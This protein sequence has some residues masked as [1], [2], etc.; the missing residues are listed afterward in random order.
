MTPVNLPVSCMCVNERE[1]ERDR[2]VVV[3]GLLWYHVGKNKVTGKGSKRRPA[4]TRSAAPA[5]L[6][7]CT[8]KMHTNIR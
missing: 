7:T 5:G 4:G 8:E 3:R 2:G 6:Y 1:R